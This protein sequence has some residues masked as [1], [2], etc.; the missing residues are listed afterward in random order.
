MDRQTIAAQR[1]DDRRSADELASPL[2]AGWNVPPRAERPALAF[3]RTLVVRFG[4]I[5][6]ILVLTPALRALR[7]ARPGARIDVLTTDDGARILAG[8]PHVDETLVFRRR[9]IPA[10][11]NVERARLVRTLRE[12]RYDVVFLLETAD[13]YRRLAHAVR[14]PHLFSIAGE[15]E[16]ATTTRP[17]HS[18]DR[19]AALLFLDVLALAGIPADRV[20]YDFAVGDD[21]RLGAGRILED[22]GVADDTRLAGVHAGHFVRRRRQHPHDKAWPVDR[23]VSVVRRLRLRGLTVVLTGS[24]A[25]SVLNRSIVEG[26]G[27]EAADP[28]PLSPGASTPRVIDLA[29]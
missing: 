10:M 3:D 1:E 12:R 4:R 24:A 23:Y 15:G 26:L 21:A 9:R 11:A 29:G 22:L 20:H 25:D 17:V 27:Q 16:P 18:P 2:P 13:R 8:N 5:G 6:D 28:F 7:R 14:A 19:H